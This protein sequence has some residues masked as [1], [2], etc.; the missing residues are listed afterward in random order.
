MIKKKTCVILSVLL[1]FVFSVPAWADVT[2]HTEGAYTE[3]DLAIYIY[4][5]ISGD[6]ILS[7][8]VKL[9]YSQAELTLTSAVKNEEVWYMGDGSSN[10]AYMDPDTSVAGEVVIIC[11]KLDSNEGHALDGVSGDRVLLGI[12]RFNRNESSMPPSTPGFG[13]SLG[14]GKPHPNFDNFV[15]T[16]GDVRDDDAGIFG[17]ITIRERGDANADGRINALDAGT[18]RDI[19]LGSGS[20]VCYADCNDDGNINA[21]DAG[22]IRDK[23]FYSP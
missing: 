19:F 14:L 16:D 6:A 7:A 20:Y 8:G 23:F 18:V 11:G 10:E 17:A 5:D 1:L 21:L 4:A 3:T 22:C 12:V 9:T 2:L 13:I 15:E